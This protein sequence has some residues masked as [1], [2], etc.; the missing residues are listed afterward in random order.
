MKNKSILF[1]QCACIITSLIQ[2]NVFTVSV[3]LPTGG[4]SGGGGGAQKI[5]FCSELGEKSF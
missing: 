5:E 3:L 1:V 2:S 4:G